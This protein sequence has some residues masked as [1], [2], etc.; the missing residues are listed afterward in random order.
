MSR[1]DYVERVGKNYL[2]KLGISAKEYVTWITTPS[3]PLDLLA[4]FLIARL[5]RFHIVVTFHTGAFFSDA[6][7]NYKKASSPWFTRLAITSV[8]P[9]K[10]DSPGSTFSLLLT[11]Q[12]LH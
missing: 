6:D 3:F 11:K 12:M 8:K 9:A 5:Y 4:M 1:L 2:D 10:W 7:R